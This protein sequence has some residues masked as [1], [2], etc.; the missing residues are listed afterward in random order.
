MT[1][2]DG[3]GASLAGELRGG[4]FGMGT[5]PERIPTWLAFPVKLVRERV[6]L[7]DSLLLSNIIQHIQCF[8]CR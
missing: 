4:G 1:R 2:T 3:P 6:N 8:F 7:S 5:Q